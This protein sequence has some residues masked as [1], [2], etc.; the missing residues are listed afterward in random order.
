MQQM[1]KISDITKF[2]HKNVGVFMKMIKNISV[3]MKMIFSSYGMYICILFTVILCFGTGIYMDSST[4]NEYSVIKS[5][6]TF[7]REYMLNN[8]ELSAVY[9]SL[10]ILNGWITMFIPIVA[11]FAYIP[12][13]CDEFESKT[14]RITVYRS[15]KLG[16]YSSKFIT[17]CISGGLSVLI[18]YIVSIILIFTLFPNTSEYSEDFQRI[19]NEYI[20]SYY[21]DNINL[22]YIDILTLKCFEVFI[23][24]TLAAVPAILLTSI[25]RNKYLILCIPFFL[26]Y[27]VSQTCMKLYAKANSDFESTNERLLKVIDILS[28]DSLLQVFESQDKTYILFYNF[29]LVIIAY[30]IYMLVYNRRFDCGE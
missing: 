2:S 30:A 3:N 25:T 19:I 23:Y 11:A 10:H 29:I 14:V 18:G 8:I 9:V 1:E 24:G 5:L 16:Y 7:N 27:A 28:P 26:K 4:S 20:K 12:L 13:I 21:S 6:L 17:A 15:S 22:N